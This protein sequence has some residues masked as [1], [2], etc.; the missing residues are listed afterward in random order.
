MPNSDIMKSLMIILALFMALSVFQSDIH[1][2]SRSIQGAHIVVAKKGLILREKPDLNAPQI[3]TISA[4]DWVTLLETAR[5]VMI[6]DGITAPWCRVQY[7]DRVGWV[8]GGYLHRGGEELQFWIVDPQ[9]ALLVTGDSG[10]SNQ[11]D[12]KITMIPYRHHGVVVMDDGRISTIDVLNHRYLKVRFRDR[13]GWCR[14]DQMT[15]AASSILD[16]SMSRETQGL[17][18]AS[19]RSARHAHL[20][21]TLV[22]YAASYGN[23]PEQTISL[24]GL[25]RKER[26]LREEYRYAR[27]GGPDQEMYSRSLEYDGLTFTFFVSPT[28]RALYAL[29]FT[30]SRYPS[31]VGQR[32]STIKRFFGEPDESENG[33][34]LFYV[35]DLLSDGSLGIRSGYIVMRIAG[36]TIVAVQY[37]YALN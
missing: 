33:E 12:Q 30:S 9:G 25:P 6:I 35:H 10:R 11:V 17:H 27:Q 20:F 22:N 2:L 3:M 14:E 1:A 18:R 26:I 36:E 21:G 16:G 31:F 4:Y 37:R 29:E 24:M 13:I 8:F 32:I 15:F 34:L 19:A 7:R 23:T 5:Q 28:K